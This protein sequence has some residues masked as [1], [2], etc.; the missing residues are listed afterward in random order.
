MKGGEAGRKGGQE[1]RIMKEAMEG[2][3]VAIGCM[4]NNG[5]MTRRKRD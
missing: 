1:K 2:R 3:M 4:V 5:R